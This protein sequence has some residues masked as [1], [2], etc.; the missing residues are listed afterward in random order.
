MV[1]RKA[2]II[3]GIIL[4]FFGFVFFHLGGHNLVMLLLEHIYT[5][6]ALSREKM[7]AYTGFVKVVEAY[8]EYRRVRLDIYNRRSVEFYD[9]YAEK[10][11]PSKGVIEDDLFSISRDF[12]RVGCFYA[13]KYNWYVVF[14]PRRNYIMPT[15]PGVLYSL[16]GRNPNE[17]DDEF[18]NSNKPFILIKDRWYMSRQLVMSPFRKIDDKWP[19]PE[20]LIDHSLR[21]PGGVN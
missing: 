15:S 13:E 8:P 19:L 14:F 20:S 17:V 9:S 3:A 2:D 18:L 10:K 4:L 7:V 21:Y 1:R 16:D 6:P 11:D 5:P 12:K